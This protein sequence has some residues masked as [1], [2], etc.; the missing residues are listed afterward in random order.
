MELQWADFSS[1]Q[2]QKN[3]LSS[4]NPQQTYDLLIIGGGITGAGIARDAAS[5]GMKVALVEAGDFAG[6]TSSRSS[7]LIHGGIRY[8]EN[9]EF[10]LVFEA[11][12][13]RRLLFEMAPHLVHPLRFLLPLFR[14][15]RIGMTKMGLGMWL[16]DALSLFEAPQMHER[17]NPQQTLS[18]LPILRDQGLMGSY[19]YS[20]AYM[21]DDRL[22]HE[23]LRSASAWG[24]QCMNYVRASGLEIVPNESN[25]HAQQHKWVRVC[26]EETGQSWKIRARHVVSTVG[27]WTDQ[28]GKLFFSHWKP[29]L[30]PS[31]GVHFTLSRKRLPLEQAVVMPADQ[32]KRI[33]FAIPRHEMV[34]VGTTDTLYKDLPENV[35]TKVEDINYLLSVVEEYFPGAHLQKEDIISSYAGVR[36]LVDDGSSTAGKTSREHLI[37][38]DPIGVTFVTGG[39]YTTYRNMAE[40]AVLEILS[41]FTLEEQMKFHR[42]YTRESL[43]PF[44]SA[45]SYFNCL[46]DIKK[47][48]ADYQIS[49]DVAEHFLIRHGNEGE[50]LI[51]LFKLKEQNDSVLFSDEARIWQVE[52]I[53][54]LQQTMNLHLSDFMLRRSPL[55]LADSQH[56]NQFLP[57]LIE[58]YREFEKWDNA[59]CQEELM[60]WQNQWKRELA[61]Q[62]S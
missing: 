14:G 42:S 18:R 59:R 36:P 47:I 46:L 24:A 13:E 26:D 34:I 8:L 20:D 60:K 40:T 44:V 16:Y 53:F 37:V 17:L 3:I 7:K 50:Q 33:V 31:K 29:L 23:T 10:G 11:L 61:W 27:P 32:Q 6:G 54:A 30:K 62:E 41:F 15:D 39:K 2:R 9:L 38:S 56:G 45:D 55:F 43:N 25:S 35:L 51:K 4:Q 22:V 28:I 5:R 1:S 58:T 57:A 49:P 52:L 48:A 19:V 12:S 21:D